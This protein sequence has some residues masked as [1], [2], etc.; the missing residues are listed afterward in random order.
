MTAQQEYTTGSWVGQR[1][2]RHTVANTVTLGVLNLRQRHLIAP[3]A[4]PTGMR[5]GLQEKRLGVVNMV[6]TGVKRPRQHHSTA[7]LAFPIGRLAGQRQN[8]NGVVLTAAVGVRPARRLALLKTALLDM[9]TGRQGGRTKRR[10][11]VVSMK[12]KRAR[13]HSLL[14]HHLQRHPCLTTAMRTGPPAGT[15]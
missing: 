1:S 7:P 13:R 11:G 12:G 6:G 3:Q 10:L 5:D 8:R 14:L 9:Q 4:C 15:A 2:R